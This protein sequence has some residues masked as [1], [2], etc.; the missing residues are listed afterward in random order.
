[1]NKA[2][3]LSTLDNGRGAGKTVPKRPRVRPKG[4]R[5]G[6]GQA[7]GV[8]PAIARPRSEPCSRAAGPRRDD[9]G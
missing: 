9:P 2:A 3:T 7:F 5:A 4:M 8:Y 1:M 6:G